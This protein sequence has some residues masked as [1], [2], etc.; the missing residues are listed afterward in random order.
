MSNPHNEQ[1]SVKE[2]KEEMEAKVKL[3]EKMTD[4]ED[5]KETELERDPDFIDPNEENFPKKEE[6]DEEEESSETTEDEEDE[7]EPTKDEEI[8]EEPEDQTEE[9]EEP[10]TPKTPENEKKRL[11]DKLSASSREAQI[12]YSKNKKITEAIEKA[13]EVSEP[14]EEELRARYSD[15]D[16]MTDSE[17]Q[18]AKEI[19]TLKKQIG[20]IS[21]VAKDF[22]DLDSWTQKVDE[23]ISDP[24]V[25][26]N[27]P[28]IDGKEDEFRSFAMK[29][30]RRGVD[31]DVLVKA[32]L[33]EVED[34]RPAK[35]KGKMFETGSGGLNKKPT[36]KDDKLSVE[37]GARLRKTNYKKYTE[38]LKKGKIKTE[39]D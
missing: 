24:E 27:N 33:F 4:K 18:S 35:N 16:E 39:V 30:T 1:K 22:K 9:D 8:D 38:L 20:A 28:K 25:L 21:E 14:S 15:W 31:F 36:K 3:A 34:T 6:D 23:F 5:D 19:M 29:E 17:Q 13:S 2:L 32:F 10:E 11:K 26:A 12:L 7:E 37:D